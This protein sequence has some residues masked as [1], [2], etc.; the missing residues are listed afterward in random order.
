MEKDLLIEIGFENKEEREEEDEGG[1]NSEDEKYE[2]CIEQNFVDLETQIKDLQLQV[3]SVM[4]E[5]FDVTMKKTLNNDHKHSE[6]RS[7]TSHSEKQNDAEGECKQNDKTAVVENATTDK[8]HSKLVS[9]NSSSEIDLSNTQGQIVSSSRP[10]ED[11]IASTKDCFD[12]QSMWSAL[13]ASTIAPHM[14]KRRMKLALEKRDKKNQSKKIVVKG[15][16][17]AVT[18]VRRDNRAM[19]KESTGIWGWE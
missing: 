14:I 17:S 13:T 2:D 6:K 5:Q 9:C 16:A 10:L 8:E 18:R 15:E 11:E 3:E 4:K 7:T 12:T 19:I 1:D